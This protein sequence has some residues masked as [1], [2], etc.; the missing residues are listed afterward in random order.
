MT[1]RK[2]TPTASANPET[3]ATH[4]ASAIQTIVWATDLRGLNSAAKDRRKLAKA[5]MPSGKTKLQSVGV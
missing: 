5:Y 1:R 3:V 2:S 4:A